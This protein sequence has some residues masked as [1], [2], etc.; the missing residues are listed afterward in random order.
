MLRLFLESEDFGKL[1]SESEPYLVEG[2]K[3]KFIV[4]LKD[5]KLVYR[6]KVI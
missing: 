4:H 5:G 2:K 6:M 3:V 1:R